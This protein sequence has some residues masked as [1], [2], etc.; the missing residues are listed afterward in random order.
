M[1]N[2]KTD[3]PNDF[4]TRRH[5]FRQSA[6]AALGLTGLVN[7]LTHL[8]LMSG[9]MAE[10]GFDNGI[11]PNRQPNPDVV[12]PE[13]PEPEDYRAL[14]CLFLRGGND[15]DNTVIPFDDPNYNSYAANRA[16]IAVP[17]YDSG[18]NVQLH[19][20]MPETFSNGVTYSLHPR[21]GNLANLFHQFDW[22]GNSFHA[23]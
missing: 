4:L 3:D 21:L 12:D 2:R 6:C 9:A 11:L 22:I 5:F 20:L 14:V 18:G 8:R 13:P 19:E 7:T 1:K 15:S 23:V 10:Q 16:I 17:K